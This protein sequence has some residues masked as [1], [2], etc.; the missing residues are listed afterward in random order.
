[1]WLSCNVIIKILKA[2]QKNTF[3]HKIIKVGHDFCK[4][5]NNILEQYNPSIL[6]ISNIEKN[7]VNIEELQIFKD[8]V[9]LFIANQKKEN[10]N[11]N[12]V[13]DDIKSNTKMYRKFY[14]FFFE[15][16]VF[17]EKIKIKKDGLTRKNLNVAIFDFELRY[18]F[19]IESV[20]KY[21][22]KIYKTVYQQK[23][24]NK[25]SNKVQIEML[26]F[27]KAYHMMR[28]A[29]SL[30]TRRRKD[31]NWKFEK[32]FMHSEQTMKIILEELPFTNLTKI[33]SA[34]LHDAKEDLRMTY[35]EL[36]K[37]F[38]E[39][40]ANI[41]WHLTKKDWRLYLSE[42]EKE[43][44]I[45][46]ELKKTKEDLK[47]E[48]ELNIRYKELINKWK[49]L[50]NKEYF[51]WL[52]NLDKD[53]LYVKFADRIHNLRTLD[54]EKME[55]KVK[56]IIETEKYFYKIALEEKER[57]QEI[58]NRSHIIL[59]KW[60]KHAYDLINFEIKKLLNNKE[61]YNTYKFLYYLIVF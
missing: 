32:A 60:K 7:T 3:S 19:T 59:M 55:T 46:I 53:S 23:W 21:Y 26:K 17:W 24:L 29:F 40:I 43:E 31:S 38:W 12:L 34:L 50:R 20:T 6:Y 22:D 16:L 2:L 36:K 13:F 25:W 45:K 52:K 27:L 15:E 44:I 8:I 28:E 33:I 49:E 14:K 18:W 57:I 51:G 48:K 42:K 30:K 56:K 47:K 11:Y 58:E 4:E 54:Q 9:E 1:M 61:T 39:E 35:K 37:E 41:V 5:I 10:P